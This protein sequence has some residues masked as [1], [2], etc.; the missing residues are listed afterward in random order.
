[1]GY[2]NT[3]KKKQQQLYFMLL[4]FQKLVLNSINNFSI[5]KIPK[6]GTKK[7]IFLAINLRAE[8]ISIEN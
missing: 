8:K 1:M 2:E 5:S 7:C 6:Q 3:V 4:L